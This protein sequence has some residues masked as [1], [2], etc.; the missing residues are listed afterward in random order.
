MLGESGGRYGV[1][2]SAVIVGESRARGGGYEYWWTSWACP[3]QEVASMTV[4]KLR[5]SHR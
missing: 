1:N 4:Q 5:A 2:D 3:E